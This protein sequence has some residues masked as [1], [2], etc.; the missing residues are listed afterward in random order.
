MTLHRW[1]TGPAKSPSKRLRLEEAVLA[2]EGL[3]VPWKSVEVWE[4]EGWQEVAVEEEEMKKLRLRH[5][6]PQEVHGKPA[7]GEDTY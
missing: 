2:A 6:E 4:V 1:G 3:G 7:K 5:R